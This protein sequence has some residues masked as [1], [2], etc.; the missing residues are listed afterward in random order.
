MSQM[1]SGFH[2]TLNSHRAVQFYTTQ[3]KMSKRKKDALKENDGTTW[4]SIRKVRDPSIIAATANPAKT[5]ESDCCS[6]KNISLG[7]ETACNP[8]CDISNTPSCQQEVILSNYR[9]TRKMSK[10][11]TSNLDTLQLTAITDCNRALAYH[12]SLKIRQ[13]MDLKGN[14]TILVHGDTI[15]EGGLAD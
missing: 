13:K 5:S 11:L 2:E 4:I 9:P 8:N 12:L 7:F 3:K 10:Y 14:T 15:K 1:S 6:L